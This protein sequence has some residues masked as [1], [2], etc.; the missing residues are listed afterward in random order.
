MNLNYIVWA[1]MAAIAVCLI[2]MAVFFIKDAYR[3]GKK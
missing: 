3:E 2:G 1:V